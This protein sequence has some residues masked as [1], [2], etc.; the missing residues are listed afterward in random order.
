M[1]DVG[2]E[3][4]WKLKR[5]RNKFRYVS[6]TGSLLCNVLSSSHLQLGLLTNNSLPTNYSSH[7]IVKSCVM[8]LGMSLQSLYGILR[9]F[10]TVKKIN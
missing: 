6:S 5:R 4:L 3:L 1:L 10:H 8:Y 2:T 7:V 9:R